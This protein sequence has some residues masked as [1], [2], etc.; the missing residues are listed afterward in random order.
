MDKARYN[1][2]V[3][4]LIGAFIGLILFFAMYAATGNLFYLVFIPIAAIMAA[5]QLFIKPKHAKEED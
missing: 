2:M 4:L 3:M 5:A 1:L